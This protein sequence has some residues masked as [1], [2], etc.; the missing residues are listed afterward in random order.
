MSDKPLRTAT[1]FTSWSRREEKCQLR[2]LARRDEAKNWSTQKGPRPAA[3]SGFFS[4]AVP[5]QVQRSKFR[6]NVSTPVNTHYHTN[7]HTHAQCVKQ[8]M[9]CNR[10]LLRGELA[11]PSPSQEVV[12][13]HCF[14]NDCRA[15]VSLEPKQ[16]DVGEDVDT[17]TQSQTVGGATVDWKGPDADSVGL[18]GA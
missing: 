6:S 2:C 7:T 11:P 4:W 16:Q 1:T 14:P 12:P 3:G 13:P 18:S 10:R 8:E 17:E 5:L 9:S 15:F